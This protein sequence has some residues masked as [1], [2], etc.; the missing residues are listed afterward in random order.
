MRLRP[1]ILSVSLSALM[2]S[3]IACGQSSGGDVEIL[4][5]EPRTGALQGQQPVKIG[6]RNFRTDIGYTVYF[7]T[8]KAEQVT[9]LDPETLLVITPQRDEAGDVD[10]TIRADDGAAF[11]I[12]NGFHYEDRGGNVVE[13]MGSGPAK[14]KKGN[15]AY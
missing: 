4:H 14:T 6:G 12:T 5:M 8:K 3:A 2:A 10:V 13:Q 15:L 1:L 9:I 11:R 7:G